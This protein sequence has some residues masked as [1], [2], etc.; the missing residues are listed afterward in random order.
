MSMIG[1]MGDDSDSVE[2]ESL[3]H[4]GA[5]CR[6]GFIPVILGLGL[7]VGLVAQSGLV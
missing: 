6:S 2:N 3:S 5:V 7:S 4:V 1:L